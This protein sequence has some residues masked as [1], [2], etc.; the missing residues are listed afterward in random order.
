MHRYLLGPQGGQWAKSYKAVSNEAYRVVAEEVLGDQFAALVWVDIKERGLSNEEKIND[1]F[2]DTVERTAGM[3]WITGDADP[4][5][6][7]A[8]L[9]S[10]VE[11]MTNWAAP[12]A[13]EAFVF[14][15]EVGH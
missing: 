8:W 2:G 1:M 11:T 12:A 3:L 10:C 5:V 9:S 7:L 13:Q 15:Q 4:L 14:L 6:T